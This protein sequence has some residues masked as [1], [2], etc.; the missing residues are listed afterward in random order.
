MIFSPNSSRV[1]PEKLAF[2]VRA[3]NHKDSNSALSAAKMGEA[4]GYRLHDEIS[5]SAIKQQITPKAV[6]A[7]QNP[8]VVHE[9]KSQIQDLTSA[10]QK[11]SAQSEQPRQQPQNRRQNYQNFR[12]SDY[13]KEQRDYNLNR[14]PENRPP[15]Y[16]HACKGPQ[17][18]RRDCMWDGEGQVNPSSQCQLCSQYGHSASHCLRFSRQQGNRQ[19]PGDTGHAPSGDHP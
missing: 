16:C 17:H 15:F 3:G 13:P 7:V 1:F 9:L 11:L 19:N 12:Q 18:F 14:R 5:V 8:S 4:Y 10:I 6:V 2:F